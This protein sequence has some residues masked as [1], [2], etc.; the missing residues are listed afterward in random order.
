MKATVVAFTALVAGA[1]LPVL[2]EVS[3]S[4]GEVGPGPGPD[5]MPLRAASPAPLADA[6]DRWA[7]QAGLWSAPVRVEGREVGRATV[8]GARVAFSYGDPFV[9]EEL[10]RGLDVAWANGEARGTARFR[11]HGPALVAAEGSDVIAALSAGSTTFAV[12]DACGTE[13]TFSVARLAR[14]R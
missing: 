9:C 13:T 7:K 2:G 8:E 11:A 5:A 6:G 12:S 1:S 4:G 14:A 3:L 10:N